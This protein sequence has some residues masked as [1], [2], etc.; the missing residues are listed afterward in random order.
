MFRHG[1]TPPT[2]HIKKLRYKKGP[3]YDHK[4]VEIIERTLKDIIEYGFADNVEEELLEFGSDG[5][6]IERKTLPEG[7]RRGHDGGENS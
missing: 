4:E 2:Q 7:M 5:E 3:V 1:L 6:L